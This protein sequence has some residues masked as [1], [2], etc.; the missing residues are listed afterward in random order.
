MAHLQ[1]VAHFHLTVQPVRHG[2]GRDVG[3][4]FLALDRD[5]HRIKT[6]RIRQAV[7]AQLTEP[8]V[9]D[10]FHAHVLAG[11]ERRQ[12]PAILRHE[13]DRQHVLA[14]AYHFRH[15]H[16]TQMAR[17]D[18]G[19]GI[20][21]GFGVDEDLGQRAIGFFPGFHQRSDG[22][23]AQ[24][25]LDRAQQMETD[26][27]VLVGGQADRDVL[28]HDAADHRAEGGR[29]VD[30]GGIGEQR[31]G[32]RLLLHAAGLVTHIEQLAQLRVG[33]EHIGVEGG[34]DGRTVLAQ[35]GNRSVDI[36]AGSGGNH[37]SSL[38]DAI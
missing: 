2:A 3:L 31:R 15:A 9:E 7:L 8:V 16:R 6:L 1:D 5:A 18:A 11:L 22:G 32:E 21:P 33:L 13:A 35:D 10:R 19:V 28:V 20:H 25:R 30:V 34:R 4:A 14:F 27:R 12:R 29:V 38:I 17:F 24:G 37:G 36:R 23:V 26:D